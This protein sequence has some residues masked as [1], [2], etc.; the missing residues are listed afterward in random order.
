MKP[1]YTPVRPNLQQ[2]QQWRPGQIIYLFI[3]DD[4]RSLAR[5]TD[6]DQRQE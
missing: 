3:A 1:R 2:Q 4:E 5:Q 6:Q